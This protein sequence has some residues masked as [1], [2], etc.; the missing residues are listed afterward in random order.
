MSASLL[1]WLLGLPAA[2]HFGGWWWVLA[3]SAVVFVF[4]GELANI[5]APLK[6][7]QERESYRFQQ[8]EALARRIQKEKEEF[9]RL[10]AFHGEEDAKRLWDWRV[11]DIK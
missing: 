7:W 3:W 11:R 10:V 4:A 9:A 5:A 1:G 2:Y 8:E 6:L